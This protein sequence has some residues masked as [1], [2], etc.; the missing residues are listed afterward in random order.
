MTST[1]ILEMLQNGLFPVI[2]EDRKVVG[3]PKSCWC[4]WQQQVFLLAIESLKS[5]S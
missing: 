2:H 5:P 1:K 3:E 4:C